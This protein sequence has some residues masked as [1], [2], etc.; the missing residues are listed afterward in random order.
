M[1]QNRGYRRGYAVAVL[2]GLEVDRAVLW[3][4]FSKVVKHEKTVGLDGVRSDQKALYNFHERVVNALRPTL[5]EGVRSVI[6][7]SPA[8]TDHVQRF[9]DHVRRH[10]AWLVEGSSKVVFS[11]VAVSAG[12][13]PEVTALVRSPVFRQV[14]GETTSEETEDLVDMLD[15]RLASSDQN[16]VMLYSIE[17]TE[18]LIT[19]S[20]KSSKLKPEYLLL[21]DKYLSS[22][23]EKGRIHRLMQIAANRNVKTR[24][25]DAESPAGV[26]LEQLGG[27]VCLARLE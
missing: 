23:R 5:K 19:G 26:R 27:L 2:I 8:R 3:K 6:L 15:K 4:I 22:S 18:N 16:T 7:G 13:L 20:R 10:H 12:T 24:I 11:E 17:E 14:I 9:L 25:V 1:K 21:T